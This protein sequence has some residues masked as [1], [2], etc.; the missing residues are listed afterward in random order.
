MSAKAAEIKELE[1]LTHEISNGNIDGRKMDDTN[2]IP[3]E[4]EDDTQ[5]LILSD[6]ECMAE[7]TN[8]SGDTLN[9]TKTPEDVVVMNAMPTREAAKLK[10]LEEADEDWHPPATKDIK[11]LKNVR[12]KKEYT[13]EEPTCV[14]DPA[15]SVFD[16][17]R[18]MIHHMEEEH[19]QKPKEKFFKCSECQA[20][21]SGRRKS[22]LLRRH[23]LV[24]QGGGSFT[25]PTC[26]KVFKRKDKLTEH[27][28]I[29]TGEKPY[30]CQHC[31]YKASSSSLLSHHRKSKRCAGNAH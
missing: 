4:E 12:V 10:R 19:D 30:S 28:R 25:C 27:K 7:Y 14:A 24:H 15:G 20:R 8:Y 2:E 13:C 6:D 22:W 9:Q 17:K 5:S 26:D 23:S 31:D 1:K 29:H 21:F 3:K 11:G 16:S 18:D